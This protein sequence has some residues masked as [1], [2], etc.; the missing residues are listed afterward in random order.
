MSNLKIAEFNN[1]NYE[2]EQGQRRNMEDNDN[3]IHNL[4]K[5]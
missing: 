2:H 3:I 5:I 4:T 1:R